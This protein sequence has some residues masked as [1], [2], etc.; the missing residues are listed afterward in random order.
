M[1]ILLPCLLAACAAA[2]APFPKNPAPL[3]RVMRPVQD[4]LRPGDQLVIRVWRAGGAIVTVDAQRKILHPLFGEL[5]VA[6]WTEQDLR[7]AI[8]QQN[9]GK[10][11]VIQRTTQGR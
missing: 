8:A 5:D 3:T 10:P 1:S 9:G 11:V 6:G 2:P 7:E 4:P